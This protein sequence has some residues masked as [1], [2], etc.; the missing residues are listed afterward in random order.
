MGW[1]DA[2]TT[3]IGTAVSTSGRI[4][5]LINNAG[6]GATPMFASGDDWDRALK[7]NL[8]GVVNTLRAAWPHFEKQDFGRVVNT[9][10]SS[11]LGTPFAGSYA[12][13]KAGVV[14]L[15]KVLASTYPDTNIKINA[16]MPVAG[17][18]MSAQNPNQVMRDWM[19]NH[20][21]PEKAAAFVPILCRDEL[22]VNGETFI[23]GGGR[24]ARV[25]F[26][27]TAGWFDAEPSAEGY[28]EHFADVMAGEDAR[29]ATSGAGDLIRYVDLLGDRG[30]F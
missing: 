12:A 1:H 29:F 27:T 17:T 18:P 19:Q 15:T 6:G 21:Q 28:L 10:S 25:L 7:I 23:I 8:L 16:I 13:A 22:D 30:P 3:R 20:F 24:A 2:S 11:F 5:I 26:E 9:S 4:D 14:G